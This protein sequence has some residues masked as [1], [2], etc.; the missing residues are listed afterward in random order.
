MSIAVCGKASIAPF[1]SFISVYR[2]KNICKLF[3]NFCAKCLKFAAIAKRLRADGG[4]RLRN[5]IFC[6][7]ING[8]SNEETQNSIYIVS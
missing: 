2:V 3:L 8:D 5:E 7:I 1:T 6:F 4:L